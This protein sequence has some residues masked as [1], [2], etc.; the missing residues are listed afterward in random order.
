MLNFD[1]AFIKAVYQPSSTHDAQSNPLCQ[2]WTS[3]LNNE[4][5]CCVL[6]A[7]RAPLAT[8]EQG[9]WQMDVGSRCES[10]CVSDIVALQSVPWCVNEAC[11]ATWEAPGVLELLPVAARSSDA[12]EFR[13]RLLKTDTDEQVPGTD[14]ALGTFAKPQAIQPREASREKPGTSGRCKMSTAMHFKNCVARL[15]AMRG[16][17]HRGRLPGQAIRSQ[18]TYP[19]VSRIASG[20]NMFSAADQTC[21]QSRFMRKRGLPILPMKSLGDSG[22]IMNLCGAESKSSLFLATKLAAICYKAIPELG[23]G[24]W[25]R[26]RSIAGIGGMARMDCS[27]KT[28][29]VKLSH[30]AGQVQGG[31]TAFTPLYSCRDLSEIDGGRA[32]PP[33]TLQEK[34]LSGQGP[35]RRCSLGLCP[36]GHSKAS[37]RIPAWK[38]CCGLRNGTNLIL[39][40]KRPPLE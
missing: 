28:R 12:R 24:Q 18:M 33:S 16:L 22:S 27:S 21:L 11:L 4:G 2:V 15:S 35:L 34:K 25:Q 40:F 26:H 36:H 10:V 19:Y 29:A 3:Q 32:S 1:S 37:L 5:F 8:T 23:S 31:A 38:G 14:E 39:T 9:N 17:Q 6:D 13:G 7:H 30:G 20:R